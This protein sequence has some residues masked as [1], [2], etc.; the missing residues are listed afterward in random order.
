[1]FPQF[2]IQNIPALSLAYKGNSETA[3]RTKKTKINSTRSMASF[4]YLCVKHA[5]ENEAGPIG[6]TMF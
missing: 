3:F 2:S 4:V 6:D 1:V 5:Q